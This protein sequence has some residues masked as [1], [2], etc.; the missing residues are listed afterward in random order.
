MDLWVLHPS[1]PAPQHSNIPVFQSSRDLT[2]V[3]SISLD[4]SNPW[5]LGPSFFLLLRLFDQFEQ[6]KHFGLGTPAKRLVPL[7]GVQFSFQKRLHIEMGVPA[8]Q[9]FETGKPLVLLAAVGKVNLVSQA[10]APDLIVVIGR[11]GF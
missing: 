7:A 5:I 8:V 3:F 6:G 11:G 1:T 10:G 4:P 9:G 2:K